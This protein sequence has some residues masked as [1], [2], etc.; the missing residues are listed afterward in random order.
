MVDD[1]GQ[2]LQLHRARSFLTAYRVDDVVTLQLESG[3]SAVST[4]LRLARGSESES[5]DVVTVRTLYKDRK[6]CMN[7]IFSHKQAILRDLLTC[8]A[9]ELIA[10]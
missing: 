7:R 3:F 9:S 5:T 8:K 6:Y 1:L 2:W 4:T 10:S